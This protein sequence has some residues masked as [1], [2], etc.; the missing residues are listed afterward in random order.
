MRVKH[1]CVH[2]R[3]KGEVGTVKHVQ[4]LQY[5]S[6]EPFEGGAYFVDPSCYM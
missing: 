5:Y 6:Y 3:N 2:I 4:A 1:L